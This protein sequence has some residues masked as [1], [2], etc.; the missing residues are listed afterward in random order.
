[1]AF[2]TDYTGKI[3]AALRET[4]LAAA[5]LAAKEQAQLKLLGQHIEYWPRRCPKQ[6]SDQDRAGLETFIE[7]FYR[8]YPWAIPGNA[9][10]IAHIPAT[11]GKGAA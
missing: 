1:M 4:R 10:P 8:D 2:N 7:Q 6:I 5:D 11:N 3:L 9:E